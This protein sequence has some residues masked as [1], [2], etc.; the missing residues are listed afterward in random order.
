M[1]YN[2]I[3]ISFMSSCESENKDWLMGSGVHALSSKSVL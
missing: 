1:G 2:M 3:T